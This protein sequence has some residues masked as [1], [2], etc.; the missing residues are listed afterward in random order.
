MPSQP[1]RPRAD[2]P[3][4]GRD[5][6][7]GEGPVG[8][9]TTDGERAVGRNSADD[10]EVDLSD[11]LRVLPDQTRDDTDAGWGEHPTG[12]DARLLA[13]RPPHWD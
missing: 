7:H 3:V 4:G 10:R 9:D 11:E 12:N 1:E 6:T 13:E 8:P 2:D 5:S